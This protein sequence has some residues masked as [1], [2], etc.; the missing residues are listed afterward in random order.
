MRAIYVCF[1]FIR[2]FLAHST[3]FRL[4]SV[5]WSL[6]GSLDIPRRCCI[7][8]IQAPGTL[9]SRGKGYQAS[10]CLVGSKFRPSPRSLLMY[11]TAHQKCNY[12]NIDKK[13]N[14]KKKKS[15]TPFPLASANIG[16]P[17]E[18]S[19]SHTPSLIKSVMHG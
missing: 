12:E 13:V 10:Q 2:L 18:T 3:Y 16:N 8:R 5:H 17:K 19:R 15:F 6:P 7:S 11:L 14:F 4:I 1:Q 9:V